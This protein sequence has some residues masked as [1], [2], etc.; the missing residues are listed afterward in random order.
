MRSHVK[1]Y[2]EVIIKRDD[3]Q[4]KKQDLL[5]RGTWMVLPMALFTSRKNKMKF[6]PTCLEMELWRG[7]CC[8]KILFT[9]NS[10]AICLCS[11]ATR[12]HVNRLRVGNDT[13]I[14]KWKKQAEDP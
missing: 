13:Q 1:K 6:V 7:G 12:G 8:E 9:L 14:M 10:M 4:R 3:F 5:D 11:D 2:K